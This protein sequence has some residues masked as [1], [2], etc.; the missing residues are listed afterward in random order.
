MNT[1]EFIQQITGPVDAA[2]YGLATPF[3]VIER[4]DAYHGQ[5]G[6]YKDHISVSYIRRWFYNSYR[7]EWTHDPEDSLSAAKK[8]YANYHVGRDNDRPFD[9]YLND[10]GNFI[11]RDDGF[12]VVVTIT[13]YCD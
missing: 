1:E 9:S 7:G 10:V 6:A 13:P 8:S 2:Q 11:V 12:V 3:E 4:R 5:L